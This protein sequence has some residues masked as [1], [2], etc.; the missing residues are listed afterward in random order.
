MATIL[1][2]I[3]ACCGK[4]W[5]VGA[6]PAARRLPRSS[7]LAAALVQS[8]AALS[9]EEPGHTMSMCLADTDH[10]GLLAVGVGAGPRETRMQVLVPALRKS[11]GV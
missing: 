4:A 2:S 3:T 6:L 7:A 11:T 10:L 1:Q 5:A 8:S 9:K